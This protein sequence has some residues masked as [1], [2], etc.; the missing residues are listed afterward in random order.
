[1]TLIAYWSKLTFFQQGCPAKRKSV[2]AA[3]SSN[4]LKGYEE[5]TIPLLK[6]KNAI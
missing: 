3:E 1:M 2:R 4:D 5:A 6:I